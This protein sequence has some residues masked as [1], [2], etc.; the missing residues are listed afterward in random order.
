MRHK[1]H[2]VEQPLQCIEHLRNAETAARS[3]TA[4]ALPKNPH[5]QLWLAYGDAI[6][7]ASPFSRIGG[8]HRYWKRAVAAS[9]L[10]L[11]AARLP[12]P[13]FAPYQ[14]P[15][16]TF[17]GSLSVLTYNVKGLPW[18]VAQGR[19]AALERIGNQLRAL[20]VAGKA[21]H[22]VVLQEAFTAE[23][24][25]IGVAA[26]YGYIAQG[27]TAGDV[28]SPGMSEDDEAYAADARWWSG[29][30]EGK[31]VGSGLQVL[32][33]YPVVAVYRMA[34]PAFA[35]AGFDCLANKGALLV[36]IAIPDAPT[37]VDVLTTHLNSRRA[38]RVSDSRSIYAYQRQ[39][40]ELTRFVRRVHDPRLPLI[41]AGD[42]N[43]GMALPRRTALLGA[44]RR[45]WLPG[46]MVRNALDEL[47]GQ[48]GALEPD[49]AHAWQRAR[50]WQ[51]Y[52]DGTDGRLTLTG[53]DVPFGRD[54]AGGM[55]SDHVGY[56]ARFRLEAA[57]I[58]S[59]RPI[60]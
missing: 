44:V 21:P 40:T 6:A 19:P 11:V 42:F 25:A 41:A 22:V 56:T 13:D 51:F 2:H 7:G 3:G 32:S 16:P 54:N 58:G 47:A 28:R 60:K 48:H 26:G 4:V 23:A 50:D 49:A 39:V 24:Q 55:L 29:E 18:P 46:R 27:P 37:P 20:H 9:L 43:V 14:A 30:T 57:A 35:C 5:R 12:Q 10:I 53:V 45:E 17:D 34:F 31:F 36:R 59:A 8:T 15:M 52:A 1:D 33:S 38:S